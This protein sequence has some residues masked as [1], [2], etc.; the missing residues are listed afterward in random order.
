[1]I[2][3]SWMLNPQAIRYAKECIHLVRDEL[4]VRLKLSHPDFLDM[5]HG[6]VVTKGSNSLKGA[7][8]KLIS[9]AGADAEYAS[10]MASAGV[11]GVTTKDVNE[12]VSVEGVMYPRYRKGQEFRGVVQGQ[13]RYSKA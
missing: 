7:Y 8:G 4:G 3:K 13:P 6:Y 12:L 10:E 1:M 5:L 9:M 11:M 2:D